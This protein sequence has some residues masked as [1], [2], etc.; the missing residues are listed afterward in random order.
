MIR[1]QHMCNASSTRLEREKYISE[2][3]GRSE[4]S[5]TIWKDSCGEELRLMNS[6]QCPYSPLSFPSVNELS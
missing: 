4:G 3:K 5:S 1:V 6:K 2:G